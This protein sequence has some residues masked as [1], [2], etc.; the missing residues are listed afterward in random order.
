MSWY[1][2]ASRCVLLAVSN[3]AGTLHS[4]CMTRFLDSLAFRSVN[5]S[6]TS[7]LHSSGLLASNNLT[8][9]WT[10]C[11]SGLQK[12]NNNLEYLE[13]LTLIFNLQPS[14]RMCFLPE[15]LWPGCWHSDIVYT[16]DTGNLMFTLTL[17]PLLHFCKDLVRS[18][19]IFIKICE[20]DDLLQWSDGWLDWQ[21]RWQWM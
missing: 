21:W 11:P 4:A 14:G 5:G 8:P 7:T 1:F 17:N 18:V 15:P 20:T 19:S 10:P 2:I 12:F 3:R 6:G 9:L 16:D 13:S